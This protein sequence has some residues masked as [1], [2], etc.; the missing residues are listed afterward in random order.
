[1]FDKIQSVYKFK[2]VYKKKIKSFKF[3]FVEMTEILIG[4]WATEQNLLR[5]SLIDYIIIA[6]IKPTIPASPSD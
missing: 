4:M 5:K 6:A 1:M 2:K 3:N